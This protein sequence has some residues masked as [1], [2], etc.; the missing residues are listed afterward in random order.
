MSTDVP[1]IV[2]RRTP[3]IERVLQMVWRLRPDLAGQMKLTVFLSLEALA[4]ESEG[5]AKHSL[6]GQKAHDTPLSAKQP[7]IEIDTD[8]RS[9][10]PEE[11]TS[12]FAELEKSDDIEW[13]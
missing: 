8:E 5:F 13:D 3:E 1:R 7:S 10:N 9:P 12:S 2:A 6:Y 11:V 4:R